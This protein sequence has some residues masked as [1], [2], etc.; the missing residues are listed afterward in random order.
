MRI[1]RSST[2][3]WIRSRFHGQR[4]TSPG[5][6]R[7]LED[8]ADGVL[9]AEIIGSY[10]PRIV[11]MHNYSAANSH[12]QK[13]Y[14][15]K[16]LNTK[17]LKKLGYKL[18]EQD[19]DDVIR[20]APGAIEKVL[21]VLQERLFMAQRGEIKV[22]ASRASS[23]PTEGGPGRMAPPPRSGGPPPAG[24]RTPDGLPEGGCGAAVVASTPVGGCGGG[25]IG[26]V[27][28]GHPPPQQMQRYQQEVDT[29]LLIEKE[30]QIAELREMMVVMSEKIKKLEQL[31]RVKDSKIE[32]LL[33][34]LH[35]YGIEA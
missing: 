28:S 12:T 4:R 29:E 8:F 13:M 33:G 31:V 35:K 15:W 22:G 11:E 23:V 1:C 2:T 17:V 16:T 9:F 3:G 14:N 18:H 34:K 32:N 27:A 21:K 30:Q 10:Y 24:R 26:G 7:Y 19:I 25:C 6:G 20:A 5:I